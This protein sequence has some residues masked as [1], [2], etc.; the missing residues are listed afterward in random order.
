MKFKKLKLN[1]FKSFVEPI[2]L[3]I[4]DGLT[5]IVGP[6]G[7]GK[8]NVVEAI[9]WV[10]GESSA[11]Q[12]R[13]DDMDDVIFG[14]SSNRPARDASEVSIVLD[15]TEVKSLTQFNE[16][17][18]LEVNRRI[19]RGKGS[20][21][22]INSNSVRAKDVNLLFADNSSGA[23]S[24][25]IVSQGQVANLIN[26]KPDARRT[27]LEEAANITG[28]HQRRHEAELRL[29]A[30]ETNLERL[31]DI[32]ITMEEQKKSLSKQARQASRYKSIGD[33]LRKAES[34]LLLKKY[35]EKEESL[36]SF[37]ELFN[38]ASSNYNE[39]TKKLHSAEENRIKSNSNLPALRKKETESFAKLQNLKINLSSIDNELIQISDNQNKAKTS[40]NNISENIKREN[41][42]SKEAK[43]VLN[44]LDKE[45]KTLSFELNS[46]ETNYKKDT[47]NLN[48]IRDELEKIENQQAEINSVINTNKYKFE[49]LSN[50]KITLSKNAEELSKESTEYNIETNDQ[51]INQL[52]EEI[53]FNEKNIISCQKNIDKNKISISKASADQNKYK[54]IFEISLNYF[55]DIEAE[56]NALTKLLNINKTEKNSKLSEKIKVKDGFENSVSH[57]LGESLEGSLVEG[58]KPYWVKLQK[59]NNLS[60]PEKTEP[61]ENFIKKLSF[62][63]LSLSS[64]GIA[65][66]EEDA[67]EMQSQLLPGQAIT[68]SK[69]GLWRWDGFIIPVGSNSSVS[70]F[71]RQNNRLR[72]LKKEINSYSEKLNSDEDNYKSYSK[73]Y[74][75]LKILI[76]EESSKLFDLKEN[77]ASL[78][79]KLSETVLEHKNNIEKRELKTFEIKKIEK[80]IFEIDSEI[81]KFS[82]NKNLEQK[83]NS[84]SKVSNKL[85]E[86]LSDKISNQAKLEQNK[87]FKISRIKDIKQEI[88]GWEKRIKDSNNQFVELKAKE[89][90]IKNYLNELSNKPSKLEKE[91]NNLLSEIDLQEVECKKISDELI[92]SERKFNEIDSECK[93]IEIELRTA[94]EK[95]IKAESEKNIIESELDLINQQILSKFNCAPYDLKENKDI[96][97]EDTKLTHEELENRQN[98][99]IRERDEMGPVN[100][101]A[102]IEMK[103]LEQ[104]I[105]N[106]LLESEDLQNAIDKLRLSIKTLNR[107]GKERI[108]VSFEKVQ[109]QFQKIFKQLFSGGE[110]KLEFTDPSDPLN[111]GLE[112]MAKPPG[113]KL[114]TLSLLSGGEKALTAISLLFAV[115]LTN[116]SPLCVLDE[117]DAPLDDTNVARFCDLLDEIKDA[118]NTRFMIITH[119]RLTMARMDRLYGVTMSENGVSQLVSVN[120]EKAIKLKETA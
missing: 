106:I 114:Q 59:K 2:D 48:S 96:K 110:A 22:T 103:E 14:G 111:S 117:V 36:K 20:S 8:S 45:S 15:N 109:V 35:L 23:R 32:V 56:Y 29:N 97:V 81:K 17:D 85:R 33:R 43:Q 80:R 64:V 94:N 27:L 63:K 101:R 77:K 7:C 44:K 78:E 75:D 5:G 83:L 107:E 100:L 102:E 98:R 28:L 79:F 118:T 49:S 88:I 71:L 30:A 65:K 67:K 90:E 26:A 40:L 92:V 24:S 73:K 47:E 113:K 68:T 93:N 105:S 84:I 11:K 10:M 31:G 104:Q 39:L 1:G 116:P 115:F 57:V 12:M 6:N 9:K 69:G 46:Q 51:K 86:E 16:Y 34:I 52:K 13:G 76:D 50:E 4:Q 38:N 62:A 60:P 108:L 119:H 54:E 99:L 21:W 19:E 53:S 120:L 74:E 66:T 18:E 112:I 89:N 37:D 72:T 87:V 25:G 58:D 82:K 55:R 95:R 61:L 42:L 91:K 70:E 41:S 3:E